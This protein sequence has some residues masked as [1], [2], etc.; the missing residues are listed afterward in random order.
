MRIGKTTSMNRRMLRC[1]LVAGVFA[2]TALGAHAD[3]H[4]VP[5]SGAYSTHVCGGIV[6][7]P[8]MCYSKE[9]ADGSTGRL[10][11]LARATSPHGG[12]LPGGTF[13]DSESGVYVYASLPNAAPSVTVRIDYTLERAAYA[14]AGN[15]LS[16]AAGTAWIGGIASLVESSTPCNCRGEAS[17]DLIPAGFQPGDV[18]GR[19]GSVEFSVASESGDPVPAGKLQVHIRLFVESSLVN[20]TNPYVGDTGYAEVAA[21]LTVNSVTVTPVA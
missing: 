18:P 19:T 17:D 5:Y 20:P 9:E 12:T 13:T 15:I 7:L 8:G 6:S 2:A 21:Y 16:Y 1:M 11:A 3:T 4:T 14:K 10:S